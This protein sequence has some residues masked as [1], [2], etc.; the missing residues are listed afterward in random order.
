MFQQPYQ[1]S[2]S[3]VEQDNLQ[4]S[5][6]VEFCDFNSSSGRYLKNSTILGVCNHWTLDREV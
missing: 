5:L 3:E 6:N 1:N 4:F 2:P